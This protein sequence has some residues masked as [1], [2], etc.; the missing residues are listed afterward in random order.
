VAYVSG[1]VTADEL[2]ALA[3][4]API[5][6]VKNALDD[7]AADSKWTTT[8]TDAGADISE[9]GYEAHKAHGRY[10]AVPTRA[11][12]QAP[13]VSAVY[14]NVNLTDTLGNLID[15]VAILGH[16]FGDVAGTV[17]VE[18]MIDDNSNFD[19]GTGTRK[20]LATFTPTT[21]QRLVSLDLNAADERYTNVKWLRVKVSSTSPFNATNVLPHIGYLLLGRR[22]QLS[23]KGNEPIT[24][25]SLSTKKKV[26]TADDGS[27]S[28]FVSAERRA[29]GRFAWTSQLGSDKFSMDDY[30]TLLSWY[31]EGGHKRAFLWIEDP[32]AAPA[33]AP[34][35]KTG[36]SYGFEGTQ[37]S[38]VYDIG[39]SWGE[40][41]PYVDPEANP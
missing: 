26:F 5:L 16:N 10:S 15:M 39:L 40:Q 31:R 38:D 17:T 36:A 4:N 33:Y 21:N 25:L 14:L 7:R 34:W 6:C 13:D 32:T 29:T 19:N 11:A 1:T 23:A 27:T 24:L 2:S 9:A 20:V 41:K 28:D 37:T 22:R 30:Q 3:A 18:V 8:G 12:D 35:A